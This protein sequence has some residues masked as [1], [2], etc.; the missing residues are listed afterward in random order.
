MKRVVALLIVV[1]LC[2]CQIELPHPSRYIGSSCIDD[3]EAKV[4]AQA[5]VDRGGWPAGA[6]V[7][8]AL[9]VYIDGVKAVSYWECKVQSESESAGYVLVNANRTDLVI[10]ESSTDGLTLHDYYQGRIKASEFRVVRYDWFRNA[11]ISSDNEIIASQGMGENPAKERKAYLALLEQRGNNPIHLAGDVDTYYSELDADRGGMQIG[12]VEKAWAKTKYRD[13]KASLKHT[14][15]SGW[16]T[17]QWAQFKKSNGHAIG[18][19]PVAWAIVY[20]YWRTF[21]GKTKLFGGNSVAEMSYVKHSDDSHVKTCI[22]RLAKLCKT[23]DQKYQGHKVGYTPP[24]R[25]ELGIKYAKECGYKNSSHGRWRGTEFKKF[26]RVKSFLDAD[27][28]VI[29]LIK[30]SGFGIPNHYVIIEEA[31][32]RQ[33]KKLRSWKDRDVKYLVNYGWG[34]DKRKWIY[35]REKGINDHKHYTACSAFRVNVQ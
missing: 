21:K 22:E 6:R 32:K 7:S 33:R 2:T 1:F 34:P 17:P 27:K 12:L 23:S 20:A 35:V 28:P 4:I 14:F 25:M 30:D 16:H 18:C 8:K 29:L 26:D 9:P 31:V 13:I 19:G 3:D 11:A 15:K 10:P 24:G 5:E